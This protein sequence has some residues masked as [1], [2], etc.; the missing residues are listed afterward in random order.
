[1]VVGWLNG[2]GW[3]WGV[4]FALCKKA[5]DGP[6]VDGGVRRVCMMALRR[7]DIIGVGRG[8]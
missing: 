7:K 6:S 8:R 2:G 1:M 4:G 3:V 5:I